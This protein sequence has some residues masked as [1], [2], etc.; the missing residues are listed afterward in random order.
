MMHEVVRDVSE[1][2]HLRLTCVNCRD[3]LVRQPWMT[4]A[5]WERLA[6]TFDEQHPE[7]GCNHLGHWNGMTEGGEAE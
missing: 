7:A 1:T 2:G 6:Q 3:T 4:Q 5:D